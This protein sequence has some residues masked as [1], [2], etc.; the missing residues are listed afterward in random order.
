MGCFAADVISSWWSFEM[1]IVP[2]SCGGKVS[3]GFER[4]LELENLNILKS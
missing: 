1:I 4:W 3:G 2:L